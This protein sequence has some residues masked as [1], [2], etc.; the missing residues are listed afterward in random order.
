MAERPTG[1]LRAARKSQA[2]PLSPCP[3]LRTSSRG[4]NE[5]PEDA[6]TSLGGGR[7]PGFFATLAGDGSSGAAGGY[8]QTELVEFLCR[9][10]SQRQ[11]AIGAMPRGELDPQALQTEASDQADDPQMRRQQLAGIAKV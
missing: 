10:R 7:P 1:C 4:K 8:E 6:A 5:T 2:I 3:T 9:H 11:V